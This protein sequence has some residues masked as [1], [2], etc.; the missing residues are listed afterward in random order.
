MIQV[1]RA[2]DLQKE[3]GWTILKP[4]FFC[5]VFFVFV[6]PN[7]VSWVTSSQQTKKNVC[8]GHCGLATS[9]QK[10]SANTVQ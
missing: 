3:A 6:H 7:V 5:F 10:V 8:V 4:H 1:Q 2:Q 9:N